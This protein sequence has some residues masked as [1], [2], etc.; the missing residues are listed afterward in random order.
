MI[1]C[2]PYLKSFID[3]TKLPSCSILETP[4]GVEYDTI[5]GKVKLTYENNQWMARF[6]DDN[7]FTIEP[8]INLKIENIPYHETE[9]HMKYTKQVSIYGYLFV[10]S[11]NDYFETS[12]NKVSNQP[13]N[14]R[15]I[16]HLQGLIEFKRA[17]NENTSYRVCKGCKIRNKMGDKVKFL[18]ELF[19][20]N[21]T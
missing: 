11:F 1:N 18:I 3:K 12:D 2:E 8:K 10:L 17:N 4:N 21:L 16:Y 6:S 5:K 14:I 20:P 15:M 19:K 13:L 7:I 9:P